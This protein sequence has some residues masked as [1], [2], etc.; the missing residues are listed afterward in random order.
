MNFG[1]RLNDLQQEIITSLCNI[2]E[3]PEGLLPHCVYVEEDTEQSLICGNT[4][5]SAYNLIR[6]FPDGSCIL[7]NPETGHEEKRELREINID[8]LV[9]VWD[10]YKDLSGVKETE[11]VKKELFAFLYPLEHFNRNATDNEIISGWIDDYVE[12]LT[13]DEFAERIN[14][15]SFNEH[16]DWV[17]FIEVEA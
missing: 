12:R 16:T 15:E 5:F 14:D 8:W 4:V 3:F 11:P 2:D 17:R 10:Y 13:L 1:K 6:I 9:M 7:E